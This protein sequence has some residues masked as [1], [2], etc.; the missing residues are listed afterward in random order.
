MSRLMHLR[1]ATIFAVATG[2]ICC[3]AHNFSQH[4]IPF[5]QPFPLAQRLSILPPGR[6]TAIPDANISPRTVQ[7]I[8]TGSLSGMMDWLPF[9]K[10]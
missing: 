1:K 4:Q 5:T 8:S 3:C 2:S 10:I 6:D 9:M 7:Q